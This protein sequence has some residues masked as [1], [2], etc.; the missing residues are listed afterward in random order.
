MDNDKGSS[1][2]LQMRL[3]VEAHD[4]DEAV[5]FY[6]DVLG[7]TEELVVHGSAGFL[8]PGL[9]S[10]CARYRGGVRSVVEIVVW[11]RVIR[12]AMPTLPGTATVG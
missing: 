12:R 11:R 2:V 3:V 7:A 8:G 5:S 6:R 1:R 9:G 10:D 4:Y